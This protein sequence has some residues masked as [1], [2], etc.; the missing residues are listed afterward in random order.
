MAFL[1]NLRS[2]PVCLILNS[3]VL[4]RT[5]PGPASPGDMCPH[6]P[7][8]LT[9][10]LGPTCA[11]PHPHCQSGTGTHN[12]ST[13]LIFPNLSS[14][15]R[16]NFLQCFGLPKKRRKREYEWWREGRRRHR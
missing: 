3:V 14:D 5:V 1:P 9:G 12:R 4:L 16:S 10:L 6:G 11:P 7:G 13:G 15:S 8:S 2:G